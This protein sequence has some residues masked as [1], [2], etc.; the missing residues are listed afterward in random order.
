MTYRRLP[1]RG[2]GNSP[3]AGLNR[4]ADPVERTTHHARA[5][6]EYGPLIS[7]VNDIFAT[8]MFCVNEH[9]I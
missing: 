4:D 9:I 3:R 7:D 8:I 2:V 6:T 1:A 5:V